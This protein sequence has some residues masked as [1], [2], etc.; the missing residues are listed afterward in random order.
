MFCYQCEQTVGGKGCTKRGVCG[1]TPEIANLQDLLIYQLKG[2]SCYAKEIL[3]EGGNIDQEV[4]KFVENGLFTTLTNVN[5]DPQVHINLLKKSQKIK[6]KLRKI[7][8]KG[9]YPEHAIYNLSDSKDEMLKDAIKAGIMYDDSLD[10]DIRSLRSTILY[11]LKGI[12]AYGHQ[13]RFINFIDKE[14]DNF[15]FKAL[16]ATTNNKL[17]SEDLI[18]LTMKTGNI[19]IA[20][21]KLLDDANTIKYKNPTPHKVNITLKKGPFIIVSGHDLRDLEMLLEQSEGKGINIYTHGE[22]LPAHGYDGLKKYKH[23]VGNFG[24]AWQNQQKEF[25]DIPG[26]ILMT[27]NCLMQPRESY[28]DRIY[29]TSVVGWEGIK[30]IK[31]D[32]DGYKDFSEI[33]NKALELGGY[34]EDEEYK[35]ILV[36]FGH[37]ATLS[38]AEKIVSAVNDGNIKHF[39]VIGGCDGARPGRNYYTDFAKLV[40]KD[41]IILT[42]AC[43]KYRF[44]KLEFGEVAGL[45]RLLDIGQCN[46]LYSAVK[47]ATSL[48]DAFDTNVNSLPLSII[49]SWYEQKAVADLLALLALGIRGIY[50]GPSLP[51]FLSPNVLQYL[52]D[53]FDLKP[54]STPEEDLKSCLRQNL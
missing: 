14:V 9:E 41:C 32:E 50:L 36:G 45:P 42:L 34:D 4:V 49:L 10:Q 39:F 16:E 33:I 18:E 7:A 37:K 13:A 5:F 27:T 8:P 6:E 54:I 2:I 21:M 46:D 17:S 3:D 47:I 25:D 30:H 19:A 24:S 26:C 51:A 48:A 44:N 20:V 38:N 35:E 15:Y 23:L 28:K 40:P 31:A 1:K 29:S 43:G 53:N 12:A 11:G 52:V 22:M